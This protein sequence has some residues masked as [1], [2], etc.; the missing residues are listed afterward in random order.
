MPLHVTLAT[1]ELLSGF[2]EYL[3]LSV[4]EEGDLRLVFLSNLRLMNFR[5]IEV[6]YDDGFYVSREVIMQKE[7]LPDRPIVA[8]WA[9]NRG[10]S[11]MDED[12]ETRYFTLGYEDDVFLLREF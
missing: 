4:L 11:F 8:M 10:I 5:V 7:L 12:Y 3:D 9:E 6:G 1:D 2:G